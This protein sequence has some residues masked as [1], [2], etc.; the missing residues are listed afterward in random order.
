VSIHYTREELQRLVAARHGQREAQ[1]EDAFIEFKIKAT[2]ELLEQ[3]IGGHWVATDGTTARLVSV[4]V[5][6]DGYIEP[7][8]EKYETAN[9]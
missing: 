4:W 6:D 5:T 7:I 9:K 3:M 1:G 2:P 8:F